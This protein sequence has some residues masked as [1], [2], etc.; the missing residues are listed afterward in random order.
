MKKR[1]FT[2]VEISAA[3]AVMGALSIVSAQ[4]SQF[5]Y[6]QQKARAMGNEIFQYNS[7]VSRYLAAH[8]GDPSVIGVS[9][10][11]DVTESGS[12]W[13]KG[14]TCGGSAD[15]DYLA[16]D[17][18]PNGV[19][20]QENFA[21]TTRIELN[22]DGALQARTVWNS[23]LGLGGTEN[24]TMMGLASLVASGNYIS[25]AE[26]GAS[27]Y[28]LPTVYCPDMAVLGSTIATLCGADRNVIVSTANTNSTIEPWLRTDHGNTMRH[29][30]EFGNAPSPQSDIDAVDDGSASGSWG[31][32]GMRQIFNVARLYNVGDGDDSLILGSLFGGGVYTDPYITTNNLMNNAVVMDGD[33]AVMRDFYVRMDAYINQDLDVGRDITSRRLTT[34]ETIDAGTNINAG[35]N[36][37]AGDNITAG[38]D[39]SAARD[40]NAGRDI[41]AGRDIDAGLD[42]SAGRHVRANNNVYGLQFIDNTSGTGDYGS[43]NWMLNP[44][45][46]SRLNRLDVKGRMIV[47]GRVRTNEYLHLN[48]IVTPGVGCSPNGLQA[49]VAD[50]TLTSCV[51]GKWKESG[52]V[53]YID[54]PSSGTAP[55]TGI[56]TVRSCHNCSLACYVNG[57]MI[58]SV[59]D[60]DKYGTGKTSSAMG[61]AKGMSYSC[62]GSDKRVL[63]TF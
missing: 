45:H 8:S 34:S 22:A 3:L 14:P 33:A 52:A 5:E 51:N 54:L 56:M 32:A 29:T 2:L 62:T 55:A 35:N 26:D 57:K 12:S 58:F 41:I 61:I 40:V 43:G 19:T 21:P 36:I 60:R 9:S 6:S 10:S 44:S 49:R 47:D 39:M 23:A 63:A 13:L 27:G 48:K 17:G 37:T 4:E 59:S 18:L 53:N 15:K 46:D 30:I 25:Q 50:G 16:C 31:G 11:T 24:S 20:V 42:I 1:G 7:A 28:Q 38:N